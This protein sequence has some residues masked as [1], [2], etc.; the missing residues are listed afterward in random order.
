M[1]K[2][3]KILHVNVLVNNTVIEGDWNIVPY[4]DISNAANVDDKKI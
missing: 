1:Y 2:R 3:S 4:S